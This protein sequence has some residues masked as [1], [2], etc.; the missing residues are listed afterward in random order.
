MSDP[1]TGGFASN[2]EPPQIEDPGTLTWWETTFLNLLNKLLEMASHGKAQEAFMK[3][4]ELMNIDS[5]YRQ[6]GQNVALTDRIN[7]GR[8][9]QDYINA[10]QKDFDEYSGGTGSG[11]TPVVKPDPYKY[12]K[13]AIYA[14]NQ[15]QKLESEYPQYVSGFEED[16]KIQLQA[17]FGKNTTQGDA[18]NL[19]N[20]WAQSWNLPTYSSAGSTPS[21][22]PWEGTSNY[23]NAFNDLRSNLTSISS[24]LNA[25][26]ESNMKDASSMME[27][28]ANSYR[29]LT[30]MEKSPVT[31]TKSAA[32]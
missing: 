13:D 31:A 15:I 1:V 5:D 2:V 6:D 24:P 18:T 16:V 11:G 26:I 22:A 21:S 17:I 29:T 20:T 7:V 32:S 4:P 23:D 8:T 28:E 3:I 12:A 9:V 10:M 19:G 27:T 25:Q 30:S 14:Y